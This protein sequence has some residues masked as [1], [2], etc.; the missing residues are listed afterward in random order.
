MFPAT[1]G[2]TIFAGSTVQ[3]AQVRAGARGRYRAGLLP[4]LFSR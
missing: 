3:L 1:L 2:L 4:T